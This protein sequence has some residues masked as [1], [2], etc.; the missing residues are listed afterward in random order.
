M[1]Y[2]L[3]LAD[4]ASNTG[5][6]KVLE[7]KFNEKEIQDYNGKGYN[8]FS[9]PNGPSNYDGLRPVDGSIIDEFHCV[10][11]D[12]DLK[13]GSH[14]SKEAFIEAIGLY[15]IIPTAI[16]DSGNGIHAYWKVLN[17]D[18]MSFLR[19]QRRLCRLFNT[20]EAVSK[21]CQL[22]RVP[23]TINQK[24][25]DNPKLCEVIYETDSVYTAEQLDALLPPITKEDETYCKTHYNK[26]YNLN[27][28]L[29]IDETLPPKFGDLIKSS[30][31]AKEL[32]SGNTDDRSK[33]DYRL[34]HLMFANGFTKDEA[35]SVLVNSAKALK[36]APVHRSSYASNIVEKIWTF[37]LTEDKPESISKSVADIL[38]ESPNESLL[39]DRLVSWKYIDN[40]DMGF[41][42]GHVMGLVAGSGVGKTTMALNLFMG[43]VQSNPEYD[44]FFI[45]LEQPYQEI[46][47]RWKIMCGSNT[48]LHNK[49]HIISN[50][51]SKG[52]FR[53]LSL[54]QIK[55]HIIDFQTNTGKKAGCVVIDHIG[56]LCNNN[57]H[58]Q[59]EG[60]KE[61]SKAMKSFAIETKTFLIMQSQTN[62]NK[63]GIGDLELDKDAAF[64]TS[65][66]E[67]FCDYLITLWQPLKRAYDLGAPTI[68]TYKFC[69][70][71]HKKQNVD[72]LKEDKPYSVLYD[73]ETQLIKEISQDI[74]KSIPYW[75]G[76]VANKRKADR[77]TEVQTYTSIKWSNDEIP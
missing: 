16:V 41:R 19:F 24:D 31:E 54:T 72:I 42:L 55:A 46:A 29:I 20:D 39:G 9:F 3:I 11:V 70:I 61:I 45:P 17:L 38:R 1:I 23:N 62:R 27:Q 4:W 37:E 75:N 58:G 65:V 33:N 43:F 56:V 35:L 30:L 67:N 59:D 73:P 74:D 21:I 50:Y 64:G 47:A 53:D 60:V 7:G 44:H 18:A 14:S 51:D 71:R 22:M 36:R 2:R 32:W 77:K 28:D 76:I 68:L 8:I 13:S 34:G 49:V 5:L 63:A 26:T 40:T 25:P 69:K 48:S 12:F 57:K 10:F 6:Q 66:F 15:E 52:V